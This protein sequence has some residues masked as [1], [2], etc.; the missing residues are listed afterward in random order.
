MKFFFV[1]RVKT[2]WEV[3]KVKDVTVDF[4]FD[5]FYADIVNGKA[6]SYNTGLDAYDFA[7]DKA[8]WE[9]LTEDEQKV[10]RAIY[11]DFIAENYEEICAAW[12]NEDMDAIDVIIEDYKAK[13]E[14]VNEETAD[15]TIA[16]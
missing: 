12:N 3:A 13:V 4:A 7:A 2:I 16:E 14:D 8:V 15:E 9:A 11:K 6:I 1:E 10:A 5:R